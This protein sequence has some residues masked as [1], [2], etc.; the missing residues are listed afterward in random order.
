LIGGSD[1]K[2]VVGVLAPVEGLAAD[3]ASVIAHADLLARSAIM[4]SA[5]W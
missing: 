2:V 3:F 5:I 4:A 1:S